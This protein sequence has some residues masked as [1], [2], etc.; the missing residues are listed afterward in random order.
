MNKI[1]LSTLILS[2]SFTVKAQVSIGGNQIV[3]GNSTILDFKTE[4]GNTKGII[5]P[6]VTSLPSLNSNNNGTFLF[7]TNSKMVRMIQNGD[8]ENL[9]DTA[10]DSTNV[11]QN[12]TTEVGSGAIIGAV[13][14][15]AT[16]VLVLESSNKAMI[17]PHIENPHTTVQNPYPGMMCYDTVSKSLAVFDGARWNYWK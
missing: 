15:S 17:L 7:D 13:S 16:G 8:W 12:S 10:G 3:N 14:T 4:A 2:V 5:L 9:S 6:T 1:I 11:Q